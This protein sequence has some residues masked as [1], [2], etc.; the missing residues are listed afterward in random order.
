MTSRTV[1]DGNAFYEIDEECVK[2]KEQQKQQKQ[3]A[4]RRGKAMNEEQ[5]RPGSGA[6]Y[7]HK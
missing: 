3:Q 5:N 6:D 2:L 1:I 4:E 7:H